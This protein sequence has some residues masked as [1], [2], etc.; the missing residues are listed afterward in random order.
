MHQ[1]TNGKYSTLCPPAIA[2]SQQLLKESA[3]AR[4]RTSLLGYAHMYLW[5]C[6]RVDHGIIATCH[7]TAR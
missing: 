2:K 7:D 1:N 4:R 6:V 3:I 5:V